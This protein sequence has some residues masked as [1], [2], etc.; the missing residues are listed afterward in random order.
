[1]RIWTRLSSFSRRCSHL[2]C[3]IIYPLSSYNACLSSYTRSYADAF[4]T[5]CPYYNRSVQASDNWESSTC[6]DWKSSSTSSCSYTRSYTRSCSNACSCIDP[7]I[8]SLDFMHVWGDEM[9]WFF[10]VSDLCKTWRRIDV[11]C[12]FSIMSSRTLL[13]S[14]ITICILLLNLPCIQH[15]VM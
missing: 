3:S 14:I 10:D 4:T 6:N 7:I 11:F 8:Y 1:M 9:L 13:P 12:P 5:Y 15:K 2:L